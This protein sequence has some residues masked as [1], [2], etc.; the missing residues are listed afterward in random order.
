[1]AEIK[2]EGLNPG[3]QEIIQE[4]TDKHFGKDYQD[5]VRITYMPGGLTNRNF[6]VEFEDGSHYAYR[7][8][9]EGTAEYLN[10]PAEHH[11]VGAV[12]DLK[13][14]PSYHWYDESTGSNICDFCEGPTMHK[15]DFQTR[16]DLLKRAA[17]ILKSYHN[18][19]IELIGAFDPLV[20]IKSYIQWLKDNNCPRYYDGMEKLVTTLEKV[21]EQFQKNPPKKVCS[22]ND[23]LSENFIYDEENDN[24]QLID[25]E[26]CGMNIYNFDIAAIIVENALSPEKEEEFLEYYYGAKPTERQKADVLVGKFLMDALWCPWALVQMVSK[27]DEEDFY[28]QYGLDRITRCNQYMADPNWDKYVELIGQPE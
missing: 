22:H 8:A 3:E 19:D 6:R 25:W 13:I 9:G 20:E 11:A 4:M 2:C 17:E 14:S 10:R 24:L 1:M 27:P 7:I 15:P 5:I 28:W 26:Y 23:V 18:S 16:S 21:D 12:K